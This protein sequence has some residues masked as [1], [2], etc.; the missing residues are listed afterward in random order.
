[1]ETTKL[2]KESARAFNSSLKKALKEKGY[3]VNVEIINSYKF[4]NCWVRIHAKE[5]SFDNDLRLGIYDT[6]GYNRN[7]LLNENDVSFGNIQ[8]NNISA[9]VHQWEKYF[10]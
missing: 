4:P 7:L 10:E 9:Y 5:K 1:M 6:W 3:K 8:K 2:N